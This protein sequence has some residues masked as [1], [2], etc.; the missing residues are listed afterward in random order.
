MKKIF[1]FLFLLSFY[2]FG[3][4][5]DPNFILDKVKEK[6]DEV[7]DYIVNVKIKVDVDFLKA[8]VTE[9]KIYFKQPDKIHFESENFALLPKEGVNFSPT[10]LLKKNYTSI[11]EKED[12][13][14]GIKTSVIKVIPLSDE[15]DII[16]TTLWIDQKK[17][18]IIKAQSTTKINGTFSLELNYQNS[19]DDFPL[20]SSMIFTFNIDRDK[21]SSGMRNF[22]NE[23]ENKKKKEKKT[24]TGKVYV[25]YSDYKVN[26]GIPDSVFEERKSE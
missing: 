16:L 18:F 21:L 10:A 2:S 14:N 5:K 25:Y 4:S 23:D 12:T 1:L 13:I 22:D 26:Q 8:P 17:Y 3:Q 15:S 19:V 20:P 7:K 24:T 9:A 6:F 11:Y